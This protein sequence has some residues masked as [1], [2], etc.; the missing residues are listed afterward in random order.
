VRPQLVQIRVW[1]VFLAGLVFVS[2]FAA[3]LHPQGGHS[4]LE[5][6]S[7]ELRGIVPLVAAKY[8]I[9]GMAVAWID[10]G[11]MGDIVVF[12]V[13]DKKSGSPVTKDT[14]FGAA[15]L[16]KPAF[17]YGVLT[18]A[19]DNRINIGAPITQFFPLPYARNANP[20]APPATET[21]D[22]INEPEFNR[23]TT[24]MVLSHTSGMP[25]WS[26]HEHLRLLSPPGSKWSYS[27]EGYVYLQS[28][29][30][31]LTGEPL[32]SFAERTVFGPFVMPH[33][34]FVWRGDYGVNLATG[35]GR[36]GNP[37]DSMRYT[38]AVASTTLY[39]TVEDYAHFII[40]VL[41]VTP[42]N[43]IHE[44]AV[45]LMLNPAI[46]VDAASRFSWGLGWGLE[47]F[48]GDTYFV[49]WG[50]NPG[51]QSLAIASRKTGSGVVILTNSENGLVAA[52]E[53][54]QGVLGGVHPFFKLPVLQPME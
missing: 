33:S 17:A 51:F 53:I 26:P 41:A 31:H 18:L 32:E 25:N 49:H 8:K 20:F 39:T 40:G 27:G 22:T 21:T 38:R 43:R 47:T 3:S 13:R 30:E 6:P 19:A 28:A 29:V 16:G 23:I 5:S 34:S 4:E 1:N 46:T 9:P 14:V 42:R 45:S 10:H 52:R 36:D 11:R 50:A 48:A 2:L 35:Y 44:S 7:S 24:L 15:S 54:V 37:A 12:G